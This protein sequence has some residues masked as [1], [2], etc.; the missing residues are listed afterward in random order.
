MAPTP[1][2]LLAGLPETLYDAVSVS[3]DEVRRELAGEGIPFVDP[4]TG[5]W[6]ELEE[7]DEGAARLA[8]DARGVAAAI[9]AAGAL[10]GIAGVPP[11]LLASFVHSL[12][13]G[14]RMAVI[15]GFDPA[16]DKGQ[17]LLRRAMSAAYGVSLPS[18]GTPGIRL[19]D[20]PGTLMERLPEAG[21][22]VTWAARTAARRVATAPLR[23]VVRWVPGL[24]TGLS[25]W[26]ARKALVERAERMRAVYRAAWE[27]R[28]LDPAEIEDAVELQ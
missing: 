21:G 16:S 12:R 25:A 18:G 6:P 19:R 13:M 8:S 10:A 26:S 9:A 22:A 4:L 20:L 14:Q 1:K 15:Y 24:A 2:E 7:L 27:G 5:T 17:I 23:R 3:T 28:P 11:E